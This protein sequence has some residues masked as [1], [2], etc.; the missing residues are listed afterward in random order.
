MLSQNFLKNHSA[1]S[2]A[3]FGYIRRQRIKVFFTFQWVL[4]CVFNPCKFYGVTEWKG[5][6]VLHLSYSTFFF[7][8]VNNCSYIISMNSTLKENKKT[9]LKSSGK[10]FSR[11]SFKDSYYY[12]GVIVRG[13]HIQIK[14]NIGK[15]KYHILWK[16][17]QSIPIFCRK[18]PNKHS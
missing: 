8:F 4:H 9:I 13:I 12:K 18:K 16:E 14:A 17:I 3:Y 15:Y 5:I 2:Q 7:Q 6:Q 1:Q 11:L 10:Y